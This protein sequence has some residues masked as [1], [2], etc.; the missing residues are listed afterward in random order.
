MAVHTVSMFPG[1]HPTFEKEYSNEDVPTF[2]NLEFR[3][4]KPL[5]CEIKQLHHTAVLPPILFNNHKLNG[6]DLFSREMSVEAK[7]YSIL[8][9]YPFCTVTIFTFHSP[10]AMN[11]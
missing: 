9:I 5:Q 10:D 2:A 1:F 6:N 3:A 7:R 11:Y 8:P 4:R